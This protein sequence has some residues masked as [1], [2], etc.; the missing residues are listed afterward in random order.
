M[1]NQAF[2]AMLLEAGLDMAFINPKSEAMIDML[3]ASEA[4]LGSDPN[5]IRYLRYI[6][7]KTG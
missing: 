5:C 3:R 7:S 1:I 4:I 6:R 2:L